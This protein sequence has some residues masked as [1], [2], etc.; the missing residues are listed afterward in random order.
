MKLGIG[1]T[2]MGRPAALERLVATLEAWTESPF[3]LVV[4]DDGDETPQWIQESHI[5]LR[6]TRG[7]VARNKNRCLYRLFEIEKC[8]VV[9]L[10]DDDIYFTDEGWEDPYVEAA[11]R[12]GQIN[13]DYGHKRSGSGTVDDPFI[14][15][16][17]GGHII[18]VSR[19]AHE[20]VGYM[21][22]GFG[23]FGLEHCDY[24]RRLCQNGFGGYHDSEGIT[25]VYSLLEKGFKSTGDFATTGTQADIGKNV[26]LHKKLESETGYTRPWVSDEDQA[27]FIAECQDFSGG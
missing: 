10:M 19:K 4:S 25:W 8:D 18:G 5:Y 11:L 6:N 1:V 17:F 2:T 24:S 14:T 23:N 20:H 22:P 26:E 21:N 12:Y 9:L 27:K 15:G 7:G 13:K 16:A 3:T